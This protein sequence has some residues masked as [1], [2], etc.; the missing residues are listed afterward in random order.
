[1]HLFA[2][3]T[4]AVAVLAVP[5]EAAVTKY[6]SA[7]GWDIYVDDTMGPG[8][9]I[10]RDNPDGE[11]Q[12]QIGIDATA[13]PRGF[14]ALYTKTPTKITAGEKLDVVF[15]VDGQKYTGVA[16]GQQMQGYDGA[17]VPFDNL[18]FIYDLAKKKAL[19]ITAKG[20]KTVVV[21]LTGTDD[22]FKA[23]RACQAA[24]K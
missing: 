14:L 23:L 8:C 20:R 19:T 1:M 3:T 13:A 4:L 9:L 10:M 6:G 16:K 12:A 2:W 17:Y 24:Q 15:D 7:A 11:T 21:N 22:A 18:D 5:C